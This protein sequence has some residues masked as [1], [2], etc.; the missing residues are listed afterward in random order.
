MQLLLIRHGETLRVESATGIANPGL[1]EA[2]HEQARRLAAWLRDHEQVDHLVVS[3][4]LR[5]GQTAAPVAEQLGLVAEVVDEL[6]EFDAGASSYIPMEE[7]TSTAHPRLRAMVEGR[8]EEF[9]ASLDPVSFQQSTVER[10][11]RLAA[12]H[13][14][15]TVAVVCHGAVINAYLGAVIGT[16]RLLWFEPRY[17]SIHR[18]LV[19]RGGV[20]SVET[21]NETVHLARPV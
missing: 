18:V 10:I 3:P 19:S 4:L 11:D 13:P 8:W 14:A 7:M 1:T 6:A 2:G 17:A 20:R 5:A 16:P 12:E 15:Q 21:I 9:G